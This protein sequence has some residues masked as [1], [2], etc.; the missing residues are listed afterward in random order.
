ML[1]GMHRWILIRVMAHWG[2]QLDKFN[3]V[4]TCAMNWHRERLKRLVERLLVIAKEKG[5]CNKLDKLLGYHMVDLMSSVTKSNHTG[6]FDHKFLT[7]QTMAGSR[8]LGKTQPLP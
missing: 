8:H 1:S 3:V 7:V 5:L 6:C 2:P 4:S